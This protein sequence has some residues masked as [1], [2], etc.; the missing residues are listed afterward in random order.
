MFLRNGA[1]ISDAETVRSRAGFAFMPIA[2]LA[3]DVPGR[4]GVIR[5]PFR[6]RIS[7]K[8]PISEWTL[9]RH[10]EN[11]GEIPAVTLEREVL[12]DRSILMDTLERGAA[13]G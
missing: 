10:L 11:G 1:S 7:G 12:S 9:A 4:M 5:V 8:L 13:M 2:T 3:R 6:R